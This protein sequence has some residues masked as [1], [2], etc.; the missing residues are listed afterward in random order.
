MLLER[1]NAVIYG[2][3]GGA[4]GGAVARHRRLS[5]MALVAL[6][7]G[8]LAVEPIADASTAEAGPL[9][10]MGP[11]PSKSAP[12]LTDPHPCEDSP[13]FTCSTLTVP[14]DHTGRTPGRLRLQVAAA[15]NVR[16]PKGVLIFLPGGPGVAGVPLI[17]GV[18][19]RLPELARTHRLVM[20]DQR[21]TGE[22][23][24]IN[25]PEL[26]QQVVSSD[27]APHT[28]EAV[29]E[30]GDI[31]GPERRFYRTDDVVADLE[32]LRR[33]LGVEK[34]TIDGVSYGSFTAARYALAHPERVRKLVLDS[35][36]PHVD[37]QRDEPMALGVLQAH[38]RVL[39]EACKSVPGCDWDPVKDLAWLVR[40]RGDGVT[41]LDLLVVQGFLDPNY[42]AVI[43]ALHKARHGD[44]TDLDALIAGL[45][46]GPP[47][48]PEVFSWG[49]YTA[50]FCADSRFPWGDSSARL[51]TR[52]AALDRRV[53]GLRRREVWPYDRKTVAGLGFIVR[54]LHWPVTRPN[55]EPPASS[56]LP[57]IPTLLINGDRDLS[58]PVEWAFEEAARIPDSKV[59]IVKGEAHAVQQGERGDTGRN[60]VVAFLNR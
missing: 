60:A 4:I 27:V 59:V 30:C 5:G 37:P 12:Q 13:G 48:A 8:L 32:L 34:M 2:G 21:G 44:P 20:L 10:A 53:A 43:Q 7:V 3:G 47:F 18:A 14:L 33:A 16:G 17:S 23:G 24:A 50:N 56:V 52:Q 29:R 49:L 39:R 36:W 26:Q 35:V 19:Q 42:V 6:L 46:A 9:T 58:T 41:L 15:D 40:Q 1:K 54:C 38:R 25:C 51:A 57:P 22:F 11:M 28:P 45:R 55:P 31:L